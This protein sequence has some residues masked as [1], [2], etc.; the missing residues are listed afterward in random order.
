MIR[1]KLQEIYDIAA[2][3]DLVVYYVFCQG[4]GLSD[5]NSVAR[6]SRK[7]CA[8]HSY[9]LTRAFLPCLLSCSQLLHRVKQNDRATKVS[10]VLPYA[11][12]PC[13][14]RH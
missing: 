9:A 2:D 12:C 1:I 11:T 14:Q 10:L 7:N 3:M 8:I 4:S 13:V 5:K 6:G